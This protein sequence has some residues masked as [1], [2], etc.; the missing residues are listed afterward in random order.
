VTALL[1]YRETPDETYKQAMKTAIKRMLA[2]IEREVAYTSSLIA[3][4][5]LD[6]RVMAAMG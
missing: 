5:E 4:H 1:A 3:K 2:D 6:P